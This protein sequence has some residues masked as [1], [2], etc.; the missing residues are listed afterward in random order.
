MKKNN[1]DFDFQFRVR[2][3][4]EYI[5]LEE[6]DHNK[7][8]E[9]LDKLSKPMK[10]EFFHQIYG[11]KILSIPF[12][13]KNFSQNCLKAISLII[14]KIDIAPEEYVLKVIN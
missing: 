12:F 3:Y 6:K 11:K 1:V 7:E 14:K 2:K 4:I 9:I 13:A 10:E 8:N 5:F